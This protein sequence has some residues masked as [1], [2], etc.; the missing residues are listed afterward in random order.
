M[1]QK[2]YD[3]IINLIT[4]LHDAEDEVGDEDHFDSDRIGCDIE[5]WKSCIEDG[6]EE[7]D[8]TYLD[9]TIKEVT[10]LINNLKED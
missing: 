7:Y 10:E 4:Q 9:E 3:K 2:K 5:G 6:S 1:N 8:E